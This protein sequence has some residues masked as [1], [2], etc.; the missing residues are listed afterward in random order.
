MTK[1]NGK[2]IKFETEKGKEFSRVTVFGRKNNCSTVYYSDG[3][4]EAASATLEVRAIKKV[5]TRH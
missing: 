4:T 2:H 1:D 5:K 3:E